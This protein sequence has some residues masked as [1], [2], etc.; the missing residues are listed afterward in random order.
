VELLLVRHAESRN[1]VLH[2]EVGG[3]VDGSDG[4]VD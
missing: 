3:F 4:W 2:A 1:N